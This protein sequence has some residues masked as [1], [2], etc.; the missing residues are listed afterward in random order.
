MT[1]S[2]HAFIN[3]RD[4]ANFVCFFHTI[5]TGQRIA[6]F[7]K[8][9]SG[10]RAILTPFAICLLRQFQNVLIFLLA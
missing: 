7:K 5:T 2:T 8:K 4:N 9:N 6:L 10:F 1:G 3:A